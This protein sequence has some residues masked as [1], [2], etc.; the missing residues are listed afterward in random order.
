MSTRSN[1]LISFVALLAVCVCWLSPQPAAANPSLRKQVDQ[2][3]DFVLFGNTLAHAC[4]AGT[5][6]PVVGT[7]GDCPDRNLVAADV[8][9]RSDDPSDGMAR[10]DANIAGTSARS[11][12][13]LNLPADAMVTYARLYWGS[14]ADSTTPNPNVRVERP[15]AGVNALVM[16]DDS[17][18]VPEAGLNGQPVN[19][20]RYWYQNTADVTDLVSAQASGPYRVSEVASVPLEELGGNPYPYVAWYI[21]VFYEL[22]SEPQRNLALFDGL[23]SVAPS[24]NATVML[25]GFLV[26]DSGFDAK[27]GIITFE[28]DDSINGDGITFNGTALSDAQNDAD[29]FFN[30]TRSYLGMPVSVMGDLP[31]LTGAANSM[32]GIDLDVVDLSMRVQAGQT[33]ATLEAT[34]TLDTYLLAAWVTSISTLKPNFSTSQKT[35]TPEGLGKAS[36]RPGDEIDYEITVVNTGSDRAVETVVSDPLPMGVTYVPDSIEIVEGPSMGKKT[37]AAG[38]D[39]AEYDAASRTI[40]IRIGDAASSSAGG[41]LDVDGMIKVRFRVKVDTDTRGKIANQATVSA[42]GEKGS[43]SENTD[44]DSDPDEPGQQSTDVTVNVCDVDADCMDPTPLC[45]ISSDPQSCVECV[46]SADCNDPQK[47][48]CSTTKHVCECAAGP[49]MCTDDTDG[50]GISDSGERMVGTDPM[51]WDTDD[52]GTPDGSEFSPELDTDGDGLPNGRD[53][54]SDND[55]LFDGTEQGFDCENKD[56]DKTLGRCRADADDTKKSN[57]VKADTDRGGVND[58]SEDANLN[59]KLDP[60]GETDPTFGAGMDDSKRDA[61]DDG[62]SDDLEEFLGSNPMDADTDDD[63]VSDGKEA[64]PSEDT[65]LD[66]LV[67]VLDVD[68]DDDA[69]RD[70]TEQGLDCSAKGTDLTKN[71]C[72]ADMDSGATKTSPLLRDT[73]TGG[74][75]DG[76][77][78]ADLNGRIDANETDPTAGKGADDGMVQDSDGDGLSDGLERSIGTDPMD[79]DSDDD[80][81]PDGDESNPSDDHDGDGK[82]NALDPD[83]DD[84][85]LF[86]GTERGRACMPPAVDLSVMQCIADADDTTKTGALSVDTDKGSTPDGIEDR[87]KNGRL[88]P[89]ELNPLDPSDDVIGKPCN[90][91]SDC[92]GPTSGLVCDNGMCDFG[93]RGM[94]GNTCPDPLFCS[95][96][97]MEV[98]ECTDTMPVV[99]AGMPPRD[100]GPMLA[101]GGK[102]GGAGCN[103]RVGTNAPPSAAQLVGFGAL[104]LLWLARR[105][106]RSRRAR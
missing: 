96:T 99:D 39:E 2:R 34:T 59:G 89:A 7:I 10:A 23:D 9:F 24:R 48:D 78:D 104:A 79:A 49:G 30:S 58:G 40:K 62:L 32:S 80:G 14:Y 103:C 11:T 52:D 35:A 3:G 31:Q 36:V 60:M 28:G 46:T 21:V 12:A 29:N 16:A 6:A 91:D 66:L 47:P 50:D 15:S 86:D 63:G 18:N 44:T 74:V 45:D 56:T 43:T 41:G 97:T 33:S 101:P 37:D 102:L 68:S 13:Q 75:R 100:A 1:N 22:A 77:E 19:S 67:N 85:G 76:S 105:H 26:P 27:L 55:G 98:G 69:L 17:W 51:D 4:E 92:G 8:Y 54:D 84:D 42:G 83:S 70:G 90:T 64:N 38:D 61:D 81:L 20:G 88:D 82:I 5:P 71:H 57:P 87:N 94:G 95:S 73:D 65:D 72:R 93:C 25:D 106:A 53:A